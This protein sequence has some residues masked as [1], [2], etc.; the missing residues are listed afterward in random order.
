MFTVGIGPYLKRCLPVMSSFLVLAAQCASADLSGKAETMPERG[1]IRMQGK[2]LSFKGIRVIAHDA[3][4][5]DNK[6]H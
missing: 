5:N 4:C 6:G 3:I 2:V 1:F